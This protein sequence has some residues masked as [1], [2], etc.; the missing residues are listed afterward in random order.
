MVEIILKPE[1]VCP[2]CW[3]NLFETSQTGLISKKYVLHCRYC[4]LSM[5][6]NI[7]QET[8]DVLSVG[9]N[10]QNAT[11][12]LQGKKLTV[13]QL[14]NHGLFI[15]SD[16]ELEQLGHGEG[17]IFQGLLNHKVNVN[18]IPKKNEDFVFAIGNISL[19]EERSKRIS[20]PTSGVGFKITKGVYYR[21]GNIG[22]SQYASELTLIDI[23][24]FYLS[25]QR[26][27]F[28]GSKQVI[29]QPLSKITTLTPYSD[30]LSIS[31]ANKQK[32][33][34][35]VGGDNHWPFIH[36]LLSGL[37]SRFR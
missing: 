6:T 5:E 30:G 21:I 1:V 7:K 9:E 15:I 27:I 20:T 13:S 19:K 32:V 33:E 31:R 24:N 25:T 12:L 16:T 4:G 17:E 3:K 35:Y 2:A 10:Y 14:K 18:I 23:G 22:Q 34:Y 29:D 11:S 37:L 26:Y 28:T 36:G 8:F